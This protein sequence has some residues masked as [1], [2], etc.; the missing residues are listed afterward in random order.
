MAGNGEMTG[1]GE[2][3]AGQFYSLALARLTSIEK[4]LV[5]MSKERVGMRKG[6]RQHREASTPS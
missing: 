3:A 2:M 4:E 1:N 6:V 5:G